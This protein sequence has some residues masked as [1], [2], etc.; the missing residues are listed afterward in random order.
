VLLEV[1]VAPDGR[2]Q[3]VRV[4]QSSGSPLLDES[5]VTTV[6]ERWRFIPAQ[7]GGIPVESRI[8]VPIRFRLDDGINLG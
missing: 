6:R 8:I 1:L 5:A 2:A 7:R 4:T 3:S